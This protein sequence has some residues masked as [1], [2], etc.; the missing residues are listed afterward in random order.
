[1]TTQ[2]SSPGAS[3]DRY[4]SLIWFW[5]IWILF[6]LV[7]NMVDTEKRIKRLEHPDAGAAQ[8]QTP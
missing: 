8:V 1:M 5:L 6:W 2:Q 4:H 7:Y 3:R